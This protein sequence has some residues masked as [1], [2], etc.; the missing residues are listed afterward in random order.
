MISYCMPKPVKEYKDIIEE[1]T[2][3]SFMEKAKM[4]QNKQVKEV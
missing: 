4:N 2:L 1:I 3:R